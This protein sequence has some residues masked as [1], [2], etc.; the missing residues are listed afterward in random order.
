MSSQAIFEASTT[1]FSAVLAVACK[2]AR[3]GDVSVSDL[4]GLVVESYQKM[5]KFFTFAYA[6]AGIQASKS[7]ILNKYFARRGFCSV[8]STTA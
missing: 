7:L 2:R 4:H 3:I 8:L 6:Y 1:N 5:S